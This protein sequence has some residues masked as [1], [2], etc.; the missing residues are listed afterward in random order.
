MW[1]SS[2][3]D[4]QRVQKESESAVWMR[5]VSFTSRISRARVHFFLNFISSAAAAAAGFRARALLR[6][7]N[8]WPSRRERIRVLYLL[9]GQLYS[10]YCRRRN[11]ACA[12]LFTIHYYTRCTSYCVRAR[13][14]TNNGFSLVLHFDWSLNPTTVCFSI[15]AHAPHKSHTLPFVYLRCVFLLSFGPRNH[16]LCIY[17]IS[18]VSG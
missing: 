11:V 6:V 4:F 16:L 18:P 10:R 2:V 5:A 7:A 1:F 9:R 17:R 3:H 12:T 8:T 15:D 13:T 14:K